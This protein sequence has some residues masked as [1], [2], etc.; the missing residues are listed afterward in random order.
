MFESVSKPYHA[1]LTFRCIH[2]C[3][4]GR[5]K[6]S[7]TTLKYVND[8]VLSIFQIHGTVLVFQVLSPTFSIKCFESF[9]R[10]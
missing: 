3:Y 4:V 2:L 7:A 6:Y 5:T 9:P 10:T 8:I 1:V